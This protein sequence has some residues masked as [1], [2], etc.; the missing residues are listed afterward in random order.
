M[1]TKLYGVTVFPQSGKAK[2]IIDKGFSYQTEK[3]KS[4]GL[5]P[6]EKWI[7]DNELIQLAVR[8]VGSDVE[9]T[10]DVF[11]NIASITK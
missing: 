9:L 5:N 4:Y 10:F 3:M 11:G 8:C 7:N 6:I 2:V 1:K